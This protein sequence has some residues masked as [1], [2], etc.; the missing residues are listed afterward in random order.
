MAEPTRR[1]LYITERYN[2][3]WVRNEGGSV[4]K[5]TAHAILSDGQNISTSEEM[6]YKKGEREGI[7]ERAMM[8]KATSQD[9]YR[10]KQLQTMRAHLAQECHRFLDREYG[11]PIPVTET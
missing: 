6:H 7:I 5:Y 3:G 11:R 4:E 1:Y 2:T 10:V 9:L 8:G